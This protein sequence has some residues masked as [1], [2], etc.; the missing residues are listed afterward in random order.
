[1]HADGQRGAVGRGRGGKRETLTAARDRSKEGVNEEGAKAEA[2]AV[3]S[4]APTTKSRMVLQ[5]YSSVIRAHIYFIKYHMFS[6][7]LPPQDSET[8]KLIT[9][10]LQSSF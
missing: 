4:T 8:N 2:E 1:M 7:T 6:M 5:E 9:T 3:M 10:T